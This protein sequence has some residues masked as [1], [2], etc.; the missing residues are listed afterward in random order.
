MVAADPPLPLLLR[1]LTACPGGIKEYDLL[2]LLG[3]EG[4]AFAP[5]RPGALRDPL[6]LFRCHFWLFHW[7]Y[8]L[9]D[10]LHTTGQGE[11]SIHCLSIRLTAAPGTPSSQ[12]PLPADPLRD[13]YLDLGHLD[14]VTR[15]EVETMLASFWQRLHHGDHRLRDLATMGLE[16][17]ASWPVITGR[18]RELVRRHHPDQGGD[19]ALLREVVAAMERLR[20]SA[21]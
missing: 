19:P 2:R 17:E 7:L 14:T 5:E 3:D 4:V 1:L 9:R 10:W 12:L 11:L 20:W 21:Q 16:P 13:Y 18:Y 15:I 6:V 8:R